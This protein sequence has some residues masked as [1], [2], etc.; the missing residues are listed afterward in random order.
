MIRLSSLSEYMRVSV[1]LLCVEKCSSDTKDGLKELGK[2]FGAE[3][4]PC[5]R[6]GSACLSCVLKAQEAEE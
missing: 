2:A 3:I 1:G 5:V 6:K 4:I